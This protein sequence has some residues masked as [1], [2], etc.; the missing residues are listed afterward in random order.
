MPER[1][2]EI[3]ESAYEAYSKTTSGKFYLSK[4]L[5]VSDSPKKEVKKEPKKRGP[6][7]KSDVQ[8]TKEK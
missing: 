3:S 4:Y 7:P 8:K 1:S 5:E 2:A 6:K